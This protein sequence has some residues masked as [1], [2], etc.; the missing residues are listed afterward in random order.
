MHGLAAVDT[1][2]KLQRSLLEPERRPESADSRDESET[3]ADPA[4][5]VVIANARRAEDRH[6]RVA[7]ELLQNA[8]VPLDRLAHGIEV[9]ILDQRHVLG[10]QALRERGEADEV[11][12]ENGHDAPL[13]HTGRHATS[14][15]PVCLDN[16]DP[17]THTSIE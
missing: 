9:R 3:R 15:R 7:H 4:L 11:G 10:V 8:A 13:D 16:V 1:D 14:L 5:G 17:A 6:R 12:E 2:S